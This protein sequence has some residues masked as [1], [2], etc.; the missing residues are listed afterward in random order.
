MTKRRSAGP[1]PPPALAL[2]VIMSMCCIS[3]A[4]QTLVFNLIS[5][6]KNSPEQLVTLAKYDVENGARALGFVSGA[7][8]SVLDEVGYIRDNDYLLPV[9]RLAYKLD[10]GKVCLSRT[11]YEVYLFKD[12]F[13]NWT[14]MLE[15]Q[16]IFRKRALSFLMN[17]Y[18]ITHDHPLFKHVRVFFFFF[19]INK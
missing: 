7:T 2:F 15:N 8:D 9:K 6:V 17:K 10:N 12:L 5:H 13:S 11:N 16:N 19:L 14:N 4:S 1:V 18:C 3:Q